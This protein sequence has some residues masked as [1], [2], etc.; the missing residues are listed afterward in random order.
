M[1]RGRGT[2]TTVRQVKTIP[3]VSI[4]E[5]MAL[6]QGDKIFLKTLQLINADMAKGERPWI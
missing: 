6:P 1:E 3:A 5:I 4:L 2:Q